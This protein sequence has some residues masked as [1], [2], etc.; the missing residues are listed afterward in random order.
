MI[1]LTRVKKDLPQR[2]KGI[3]L[4]IYQGERPVGTPEA[5]QSNIE[6]LEEVS[7]QAKK[8]D[9]QL[10]IFPELYL[11]GYALSPDLVKQLAEEVN[12]PSLRKVSKI[13]RDND[14]AII[15]P[16]PE[17]DSSSG[18][19]HYYDSIAFINSDGYLLQNY[20]KTH[21]FGQAEKDNF[22]SGYTEKGDK[23]LFPVVKVADFPVG[24]LNC[25]E[26]EFPELS[27]ILALK[28]A[29][30]VI[31]PTAADYYYTLS[32][33]NRTQVPYPDVSKKLIPANAYFNKI[34]IAYSN[35]CGYETVGKNSWQYRGNSVICGP[36]GDLLLV[37]RP[38]ETL[39]VADIIPSD[40]GP[41]HPEGDYLKDRRPELYHG[42]IS[43]NVAFGEG[44]AYPDKST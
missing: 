44:Y 18:E 32:D 26:A 24:I 33:G 39:L 35:R 38:E 34:F 1:Y 15:F 23:N 4:A 5:V 8:Y 36:N 12:G 31:I 9:A 19:V 41:T 13:A 2:G 20:R 27:R 30:L 10:I 6:K 17:R 42:L 22:S 28:G 7:K 40:F 21:L 3:R 37:A 14:I 29:R 11:T 25:Y 43:K 16:Y